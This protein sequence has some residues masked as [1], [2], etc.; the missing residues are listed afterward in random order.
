MLLQ[1]VGDLLQR[2]AHRLLLV[3]LG[4]DP[5]A[6]DLLLRAHV[7]DQARNAVGKVGHGGGD[8]RIGAAAVLLHAAQSFRQDADLVGGLDLG[9]FGD[10]DVGGQIGDR[11][12]PVFEF[13]VEACLGAASLQ[14]EEA[15]HQGTGQA[16]QRGREGGAHAGQRRGKPLL[17]RIRARRRHRRCRDRATRWFR[18]SSRSCL[19]GPRKCR[20][21]QGTPAARRD[22][23]RCRGFRRGGWR[24]NRAWCASSWSRRRSSTSGRSSPSSVPAAPA[25]WFRSRPER[26]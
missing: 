7:L 19:A 20:A 3:R 23:A 9:R 2:V 8:A 5:V 25:R 13:G 26:S 10:D 22:S 16:E 24:S 18:G 1:G 15:E 14:V 21:G 4:L 17:Q 12:Q 11:G 6:H